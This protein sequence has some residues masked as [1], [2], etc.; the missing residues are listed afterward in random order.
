MENPKLPKVQL[1][2]W[3][4][5]FID[6]LADPSDQRTQKDFCKDNVIAEAVLS[7]WKKLNHDFVYLE[8]EKRRSAYDAVIRT[9]ARKKLFKRME[10]SDIA[11]QNALKLIGDLIERSE[12]NTT[13]LT[14]DQK[15]EKAREIL[16]RLSQKLSPKDSPEEPRRVAENP[17][18]EGPQPGTNLP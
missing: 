11:V 5:A 15:R 1:Q 9:E 18:G 12:V 8:A 6:Y 14:A 3:Q 16:E 2:P 4:E 10:K 17:V 13:H 7:R